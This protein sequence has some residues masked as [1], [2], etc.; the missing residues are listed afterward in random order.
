[1]SWVAAYTFRG[2]QDYLKGGGR[3]LDVAGGSEVIDSLCRDGLGL[4]LQRLG[5]MDSKADPSKPALIPAHG[6]VLKNA[7]GQVVIRFEDKDTAHQFAR[8]WPLMADHWA[9]NGRH[10]VALEQVAD[11]KN[12]DAAIKEALD[13]AN[14]GSGLPPFALPDATPLTLR[15]RRTGWPVVQVPGD[16]D[17]LDDRDAS[18]VHRRLRVG[19]K[20]APGLENLKTRF[21]FKKEHELTRDADALAQAGGSSILAVIHADGAGFGKMFEAVTKAGGHEAVKALSEVTT[22][23]VQAAAEEAV[24]IIREVRTHDGYIACRPIVLGGD[25]MAVVVPARFGLAVAR[26]FLTAF[27]KHSTEKLACFNQDYSGA[28][29]DRPHLTAG[30]GIAYVHAHHPFSDALHLADTLCGWAKD[31]LGD[32]KTKTSCLM[33]HRALD[34]D[35]GAFQEIFATDFVLQVSEK[36]KRVLTAGPYTI[37]RINGHVSLNDLEALMDAARPLPLGT[38]RSIARLL[39]E[40]DTVAERRLARQYEILGTRAH[41]LRKAL[42][43]FTDDP[44]NLWRKDREPWRT[45]IHDIDVLLGLEQRVRGRLNEADDAVE[46]MEATTD[47]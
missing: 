25:D 44:R 1:M 34:T 30:A 28:L 23:I 43:D 46:T 35:A 14:N 41:A 40:S 2:I 16:D 15:N 24:D 47:A 38:W 11:G 20:S 19:P 37:S 33:V 45:P 12:L 29:P 8:L 9:P 4:A 5:L 21:G 10:T 18:T 3:L 6:D 36:R 22:K 42:K 31:Q 27:E 17:E 32:D 7:S 13:Q 39:R 26:R